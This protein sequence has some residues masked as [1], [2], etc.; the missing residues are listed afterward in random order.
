MELFSSLDFE[1]EPQSLKWALSFARGYLDLGMAAA[2]GRELDALG[3]RHRCYADVIELRVRVMFARGRF[4]QAA[5][6]ARSAARVYPG[7]AEF[8]VLASEA[9][10]AL[11]Q[12]GEA[13]A[14]W[15]SSPSLFHVS[16]VFHYNLARY[17]AQMGNSLSAREH[18]ALAIEL[19]PS[20]QHRA[21][22]DPGLRELLIGSAN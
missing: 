16:S 19:D 4:A 15:V 18:I 5:R 9:Y 10:E 17:E 1:S 22:K 13:K 14:V 3:V 7:I 21:S 11:G 6:L 2:A 8:Y 12:P 20:N